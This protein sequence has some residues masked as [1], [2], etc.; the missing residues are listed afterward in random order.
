MTAHIGVSSSRGRCWPAALVLAACSGDAG[1]AARSGWSSRSARS[2]RT[3]QPL[4]PPKKFNPQPYVAL[5]RCRAVQHA[6]A[7]RRAQ[8]GGAAAEFAAGGR[9]QPAQGAARGLSAGQHGDGRQRGHAAAARTRCCR[10]TTCFT[11]SS[12][13]TTSARTTERSPRSPKP[14]WR[15]AKSCRTRPANGSSATAPSSFR[16]RRDEEHAGEIDDEQVAL[17]CVG[18]RCC[19]PAPRSRPGRRTRSSRSPARQQAGAEVVRIELSEAA[20]RGAGRL[21]VQTPP[22][23]AID[24]PGVDN[25]IG[26]PHGRD[27][28]GQPALGQRRPG[29]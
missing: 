19:W 3:S 6:E 27:Q 23:I 26:K 1:R 11:R 10:S 28:P 7:H 4:S 16:R 2:S 8:A 18:A 20:G 12:R 24:L 15:C 22:R 14:M 21:H 5:G 29:R 13:A 9:D 17:A 25:A